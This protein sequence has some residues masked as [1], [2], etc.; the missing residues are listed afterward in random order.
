METIWIEVVGNRR[1]VRANYG[2]MVATLADVRW[3]WLARLLVACHR[4]SPLLSPDP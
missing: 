3:R 2:N 1:I 4:G